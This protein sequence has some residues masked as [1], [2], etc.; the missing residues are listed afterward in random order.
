MSCC[1]PVT[2][3]YGQ[4]PGD[5]AAAA[6]QQQPNG[7][8]P[9][10]NQQTMPGRAESSGR[11][12]LWPGAAPADA[13]RAAAAPN[14]AGPQQ[15]RPP[16]A[17]NSQQLYV[18]TIDL[19]GAR[20]IAKIGQEV[21]L[22][23]EVSGPVDDHMQQV[24]SQPGADKIPKAEVQAYREKLSRERL[25]HLIDIKLA[26]NDARRKL[27][28][29]TLKRIMSSIEGDFDSK[30]VPRKV[31]E[32]KIASRNEFDTMLR[33]RGSSL[34]KERRAYVEQQ[35][36]F[37]WL[38]QATKSKHEITHTD[39]LAYYQQHLTDYEF[40]AKAKFEQLMVR[41]PTPDARDAARHALATMGNEVW[42]GAHFADVARAR[43]EGITAADGGAFD[44]THPGSLAA[45]NLDKAVF[46]LE[47]GRLSPI[48]EDDKSMSII[49]VTERYP[50]G[51]K[52]FLEVQS[53]IK[54]YLEQKQKVVYNEKM[55]EFLATRREET[56]IWTIYDQIPIEEAELI[57]R[58]KGPAAP[59]TALRPTRPAEGQSPPTQSR[60]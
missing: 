58:R 21:V 17:R 46:S 8:N 45:I 31:K 14:G 22:Q 1:A 41:V 28:D 47:I 34:E 55:K 4:A 35:L 20:I 7:P 44:W 24:L 50:A 23:S 15:G 19:N 9:Y 6:M 27:P 49:R 33:E 10:Y 53:E 36:A 43:S 48:I 51:R 30:E 25:E 59:S 56:P 13:N 29:D 32:L 2:I 57:S 39:L 18:D 40:P 54:E 38:Q 5:P 12:A 42:N 37:G 60:Q 26:I 16:W 52:S 11:P 3:A